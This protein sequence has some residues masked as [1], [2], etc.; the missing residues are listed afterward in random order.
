VAARTL[1][2]AWRVPLALALLLFDGRM[3]WAQG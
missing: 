2:W 3:A 1:Q